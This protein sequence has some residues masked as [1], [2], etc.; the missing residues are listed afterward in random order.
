MSSFIPCDI[1]SPQMERQCCFQMKSKAFTKDSA[2]YQTGISQRCHGLLTAT[3]WGRHGSPK[4]ILQETEHDATHVHHPCIFFWIVLSFEYTVER[5][6]RVSLPC[7][8]GHKYRRKS[9]IFLWCHRSSL[10]NKKE[11]IQCN[12]VGKSQE[13]NYCDCKYFY[14]NLFLCHVIPQIY[15]FAIF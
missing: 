5:V 8:V 6:K 9:H 11:Y 15:Q 3:M 13:H 2:G 14:R 12:L 1:V 10:Q 7:K 4:E